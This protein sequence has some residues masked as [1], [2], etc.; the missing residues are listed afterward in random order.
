V[1]AL[2]VV[3]LS[4]L[5]SVAGKPLLET[6]AFVMV[7]P[8]GVLLVTAGFGVGPA[9]F[10]GITGLLVFDFVFVPPAL[11]FAVPDAKNALTLAIMIAVAGVA[12][13]LAELLR[14]QAR[15]A[16]QQVEVERLRNALL[17]VLSHDLRTPLTA[18]VGASTALCQEYLAP[19]TR[20]N[21]S[22][23]VADEARRL[24]RLV[25][26]LLEMTRVESGHIAARPVLQAID[27]VIGAALAHLEASLEGRRVHTQ[28]PEDIPLVA[29]DPVL[30]EQVI[31]NLVENAVR[32]AGPESPIEIAAR[33][34]GQFV[35][36][37]VADRGPGV[38]PGD[39][40]RV[41]DRLYR[42]SNASAGG[43][44]L[45]LTICRAIVTAHCGRIWFENRPG[46]G[47]LVAFT[48]PVSRSHRGGSP[49]G[50]REDAA[51]AP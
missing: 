4:T 33:I 26:S 24:N 38:P 50:V 12:G 51:T 7:F 45:G 27:E 9:V 49:G 35:L 36:V 16:Q 41:F 43:F 22:Q 11:A 1:A 39:E 20:R 5:L 34:E 30:I 42:A 48:L 18:L 19:Q 23:M 2:L 21:L 17:S 44:G 10:T 8:L 15:R 28:V 6:A 46:G 31:L 13:I 14:R 37:S 25:R 32:H 29:F 3:A 47:A 40:A